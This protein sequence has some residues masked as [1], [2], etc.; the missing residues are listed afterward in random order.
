MPIYGIGV[1]LFL[2]TLYFFG[3]W[4]Y[5][6]I[7]KIEDAKVVWLIVIGMYILIAILDSLSDKL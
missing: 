5:S 2:P 4:F 6:K 7:S 3:K 1:I